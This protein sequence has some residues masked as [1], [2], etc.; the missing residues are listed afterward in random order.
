MTYHNIITS[1]HVVLVEFYATWCPHC[2]RMAPI[3]EELKELLT[4][5]AAIQQFD[6]DQNE[7]IADK[8]AVSSV[9]TFIIYRDGEEMWRRSGEIDG[10]VLLEKV[11]KYI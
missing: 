11:E 9:P 3:V 8:A 5:R 10:E 7:T 4:D 1:H 6:I 2:Q